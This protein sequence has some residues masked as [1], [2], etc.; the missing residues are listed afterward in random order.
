[1][2]DPFGPIIYAYTRV[3]ALANGFLIGI[4]GYRALFTE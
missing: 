2:P 3:K 4:T 1:M